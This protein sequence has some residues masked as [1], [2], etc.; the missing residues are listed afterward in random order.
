MHLTLVLSKKGNNRKN[1]SILKKNKVSV[2]Y[3]R[4]TPASAGTCA[5]LMK[6]QD[7]S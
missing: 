1:K 3:L 6:K 2:K 4:K 7:K 5:K